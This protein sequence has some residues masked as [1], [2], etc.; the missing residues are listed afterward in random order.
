MTRWMLVIS[1]AF[2]GCAIEPGSYVAPVMRGTVMDDGRLQRDEAECTTYASTRPSEIRYATYVACMVS[3]GHQTYAS[4]VGSNG[5]T[6][7]TLRAERG[8]AT[9][10]VFRDLTRCA[11]E[12]NV[13]VDMPSTPSLFSGPPAEALKRRAQTPY[14]AC[15]TASG[16]ALTLDATPEAI[17]AVKPVAPQKSAQTQVSPLITAPDPQAIAPAPHPSV[18]PVT[19]A[20]SP[21][22]V[23]PTAM[24]AAPPPS[25]VAAV[26]PPGPTRIGRPVK[27]G[28]YLQP[29]TSPPVVN[30]VVSDTPAA[31]AGVRPGDVIL[32]VDGRP[33]RSEVDITPLLATK[34]P[35]DALRLGLQRGQEKLS[36]D[37]ILVEP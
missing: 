35:G 16:Y 18:P 33:I 12:T 32:T 31:K 22:S 15:M 8:Q 14:A 6:G 23:P 11:N 25:A 21:A 36:V 9:G 27:H 7:V 4:L 19:A 28:L 29:G 30:V 34:R 20:P 37:A 5:A 2:G 10:D 17:A 13:R 24:S 3:R 1:L 26:P